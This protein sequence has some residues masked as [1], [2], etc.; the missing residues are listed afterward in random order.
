M[1]KYR[2]HAEMSVCSRVTFYSAGVRLGRWMPSFA[3]R[4]CRVLRFSPSNSAAPPLPWIR[5]PVFSSAFRMCR[6]SASFKESGG[7]LT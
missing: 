2:H 3:M 7:A 5:Q 6:R 1:P 4:L